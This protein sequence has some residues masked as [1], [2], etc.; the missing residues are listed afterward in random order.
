MFKGNPGLRKLHAAMF[1]IT[2]ILAVF[3]GVMWSLNRGIIQISPQVTEIAENKYDTTLRVVTDYDYKPFSYYDVNMNKLGRDVELIA[4]IANDIG[5]NLEL[6]MMNWQDALT[7][8]ENGEYDVVMTCE[9]SFFNEKEETMLMTVPV[10]SDEFFVYGS[11]NLSGIS[12]L[13]GKMIGITATS[14]EAMVLETYGLSKDCFEYATISELMESVI[15][16]SCDCAVLR[17]SVATPILKS[18]MDG[19]VKPMFSIG[20]SYSCIGVD[21]N[22]PDLRDKI[23]DSIRKLSA[24]GVISKL[25]T[26][27]IGT[28]AQDLTFAEFVKEYYW[29]IAFLLFLVMAIA[30]LALR[31]YYNGKEKA[32]IEQLKDQIKGQ[33]EDSR[34]ELETLRGLSGY[35]EYICFVDT[36]SNTITNY[37]TFGMFK[38]L[39]GDEPYIAPVDFDAMLKKLVPPEE[40]VRFVKSLDRQ[41]IMDALYLDQTVKVPCHF[42]EDDG[43]KNYQIIFSLDRL[44]PKNVIIGFKNADEEIEKESVIT[45]LAKD[46]EAIFILDPFRD[47]VS[48]IG[49]NDTSLMCY[50][51]MTPEMNLREFRRVMSEHVHPDDMSIMEPFTGTEDLKKLMSDVVT[52]TV[53]Y[54]TNREGQYKY[55]KAKLVK[56]NQNMYDSSFEVLVGFSDVDAIER[57]KMNQKEMLEQKVKEQT[58]VIISNAERFQKI[59]NGVIEGLATLIESR[60]TSTGDHVKNAKTFVEMILKYLLENGM[61]PET[62]TPEYVKT[63]TEASVLH[64]IGKIGISDT[65]LNKPGK[66]TDE[67]FEIMKTHAAYGGRI[68]REIFEG[69]IDQELTDAVC[70][71]ATHHHE[72]WNGKGYPEGLTGEN[73][74]LGARIMAVADVFDALIS[75]RVYKDAVSIDKAY[76]ILIEDS[77]SHFDSSI[78]DV[79]VKIRPRVEE[80]IFQNR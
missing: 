68:A 37:H 24:E 39:I 29:L 45:A 16:G 25:N 21:V 77:G 78:V 12:E 55:Y 2:L 36:L 14:R 20:N 52:Y 11:E 60:D 30:V 15:D 23:N 41:M 51:T 65:I 32:G 46:Y 3:V 4:Y 66:L 28:A 26:K 43:V 1:S 73:I 33:A 71:I 63:I 34:R 35:Y 76:S 80:Y 54:R 5:M 38:D 8:F 50:G 27:W 7:A 74:S 49:Q 40:F 9:E 56:L 64:D 22:Q 72:K 57:E 58:E 19:K 31:T 47:T 44:H 53:I 70:D 61:Y 69:E 67:E 48:C 59:Q 6:T 10:Y 79:F 13:K 62:V 42:I 75:K 17:S 18:S